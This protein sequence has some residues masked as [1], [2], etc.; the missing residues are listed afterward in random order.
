MMS[1]YKKIARCWLGTLCGEI[2]Y[3]EQILHNTRQE[4]RRNDT[5]TTLILQQQQQYKETQNE[6]R[7]WDLPPP[8]AASHISFEFRGAA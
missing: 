7:K 2:M 6:Y 8:L 4:T 1:Y 5:A 3:Y